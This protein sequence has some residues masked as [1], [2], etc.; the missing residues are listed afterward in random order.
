[1]RSALACAPGRYLIA[2]GVGVVALVFASTLLWP[3]SPT[4][5]A[6]R[7][8]EHSATYAA[9]AH[10]QDADYAPHGK[11]AGEVTEAMYG[12]RTISVIVTLAGKPAPPR[13]GS[14]S[15]DIAALANSIEE[16][17]ARVLE[18]IPPGDFALVRQYSV[19]PALAGD[20]T[21]AGVWALAAHPDVLHVGLNREVRADL[22]QAVPLIGADDVHS[23]LGV[24]GEGVVVA[25]LDSGID[26]DHPLLSGDLNHQACFLDS[27]A[28][29]GGGTTGP[30]AEDDAGHGSHVSGIITS[31]GPPV[32]VAPDALIDAFKV[33]DNSGFGSFANVLAAYDDIILNHPEVDIINMSL[34][35]GG[36]YP[37]GVCD[38]FVPALT[39]AVSI[40]RAMGMTSF[41]ASGNN[42]S[43]TGIGYPACI[44]D[45]VSVGAVYDDD[46]GVQNWLP[47]CLDAATTADQVVCFSQSNI[48]LDLLAPGS[49]IDSTVPGGGLANFS[50]TSMASPAAAAVAALLLESEALLSPVDVEAR[51][52]ETGVP[53]TDAGNGVTTCR[54]DAY[55]A[56]VNDGGPICASAGPPPP[57][58]DDFV[59]GVLISEPLPYANT[60]FTGGATTETGEPAPCGGIAA[61]VWYAF[62]PSSDQALIADTFGSGYDTVLAVYT[63]P[64]VDSLTL[65]SCNDD[66][67]G[68]QSRVQFSANAGTTYHV[69]L[70]G[71]FGAA[72]SLTFSLNTFVVP[73][74]P[75]SPTFSFSVP[76]PLGDAFGS[77][78][79]NHD[80]TSVAGD[81]DVDTFCLTVE[82]DGPVDPADAGT[83]QEVAGAIEFD[84]DQDPFTG[85]SPF[86]DIFCA[87]PS[88]LGVEASLSMFDVSGGFGLLDGVPIPVVFNTTSFTAIIP[89]ALIGGDSAFHFGMVLGSIFEPTDCAPEDGGCISAPDGTACVLPP[90]PTPT[91]TPTPTPTPTPPVCPT[92]GN[93][94]F[95]AG[96]VDV[97]A[98]P[99]WTVVDQAGG[100]GSWCTQ[101]GVTPPQGSCSGSGATV[102][103]PPEGTQAAMTNQGGPGSHMLYRCLVPPLDFLSFELYINNENGTF[104]SPPTLDVD[105]F[106]NQQFRADLVTPAGIGA[107]PFTVAPLDILLNIYQT[108]P[109]D[110]P[111]SGYTT[112][113]ADVSSYVGQ[114]VCLRFGEVENQFFFHAGVDD[115]RFSET[116]PPTPTAT[117]TPTVTPTPTITLTPTNIPT[118]TDTPTPSATPIG[119]DAPPW[120]WDP[121]SC[122]SPESLW[123]QETA[124]SISGMSGGMLAFNTGCTGPGVTGCTF[125]TGSAVSGR[126]VSP[127]LSVPSGGIL[128]FKTA[129]ST[130]NACEVWDR[131]FV[132]YSTNGGGS[133]VPLDLLAGSITPG[134]QFL[135]AG[136]EICG[137]SLTAQIVTVPLPPGITN[138][139]FDFDSIDSGI[140]DFAGQFIDDVDVEACAPDKVPGGDECGTPTPTPTPCPTDQVPVGGSCATFTPTPTHTSTATPCPDDKVPVGAGCGTP[141][142]TPTPCPPDKVPVG[143]GCGTP[144]PTLTP[145]GPE[146]L[147]TIKG[148]DCDDPARPTTCD[149]PIE[150]KF[151][152]S[153]DAVVAPP[154]GYI[155]MQTFIHF[156]PDLIYQP[157]PTAFDEISWPDCDETFAVREQFPSN[158]Y[159]NQG[160][161]SGLPPIPISH[162]VGNVVELSFACSSSPSSTEVQLLPYLD[163]VAITSGALF[164]FSVDVRFIPR[165]SNLTVNCVAP[166]TPTDTPT[167]PPFPKMSMLPALQ[168]V[169]L[170][171]QG[172]KI[173]PADCLAG[174]PTGLLEDLSQAIDS[175]DPKAPSA[176]Q[177]LAAFE[178]EV[179]YDATKVCVDLTLGD[180]FAAAGAICIVED[181]EPDS[182]PQ[183]EGVARIGCVTIGKGLDIEEQAPLASIDVYPQPELYSQIKPNQDNG[184]VVQIN[185]VNCDLGDEQ[186]HAIPIFSCDDA[187]ITF[188]YLEGDVNPDCVVDAADI[189]TI[190]FRWGVAKGS[191][192][193]NDFLN[194]EPSGAQADEDIDINDLQFVYGRFGSTCDDPH[195]PQE[196]VNPKA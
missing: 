120:D 22:A 161:V 11:V 7:P 180:A 4:R 186:G 89:L 167:P 172:A 26:T 171:R 56:V 160:C 118:P 98:I 34:G 36:S 84:V 184:V 178:F 111:V 162:Y 55:E 110:P 154:I 80:I 79:P 101:A 66:F 17:A 182:K 81:G 104:Y 31:T 73:T 142:P 126:A 18:S 102:A 158:E 38:G 164:Q 121:L 91:D 105:V 37:P 71:F 163:P 130:E 23:L 159:V 90:T 169:F 191:L 69:Q 153:V 25:V 64:S 156:G 119:C 15:I 192:I 51:L 150:N 132:L 70:G 5:A 124:A 30:S 152:L 65:V 61:T 43:K 53:V 41:A 86:M 151:T 85:F 47:T 49:R 52:K 177:Q 93:D 29:P 78:S 196:P 183:L 166:P 129:R 133:F 188:R 113:T 1:M 109:G 42:G 137:E 19:V 20:A 88:D 112:V 175:P 115:V 48:S 181:D 100:F 187:D 134:G 14:Q 107:D 147:L 117:P 59:D 122:F 190:A 57:V 95:E 135:A 195:P 28:C 50:G 9:G 94:G 193:Y 170:T 72:G 75:A 96:V 83:G 141:T 168:N 35:D 123:H 108:Q 140:N 21:P 149:V 24:T 63:G 67:S 97:N 6:V 189:Q 76:D 106:P 13:S 46:V 32:G 157:M 99:C 2:L 77:G 148:G 39:T 82:F 143:A 128:T 174:T 68:P 125:S 194:L 165:V 131:T 10:G 62:T 74:C 27:G 176:L 136:G 145:G 33:L 173:P 16:S 58:N 3:N 144:T 45:I 139:A 138:I 114:T 8:P 179:H 103:A 54:V 44:N 116:P 60:Q 155:L 127:T 92:A 87:S 185:N 146:M 40:T 12:S